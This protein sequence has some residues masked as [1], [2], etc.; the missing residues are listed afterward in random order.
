MDLTILM[1]RTESQIINAVTR[2]QEKETEN[3]GVR[4]EVTVLI[5]KLPF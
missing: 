1:G 3:S 2:N 5:R 4:V